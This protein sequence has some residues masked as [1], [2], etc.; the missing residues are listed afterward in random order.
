MRSPE[1]QDV[2]ASTVDVVGA[3]TGTFKS[4]GDAVQVAREEF[5]D[6][7]MSA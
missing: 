7:T 4:I 5:D 3:I 1:A 2:A 6:N